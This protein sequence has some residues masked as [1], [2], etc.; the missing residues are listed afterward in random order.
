MSNQESVIV[1]EKK[2]F[3]HVG[4]GQRGIQNILGNFKS[5]EWEEIRLDV[6]SRVEPD[7]LCSMVD[8]RGKVETECMDAVW[9]SH[10]VEHLYPHEVIPTFQEFYRVLKPTG[11]LSMRLPDIQAVAEQIAQ[12][13]LEEALYQSPNGP[14]CPLDILY[15][16]RP[17]LEKGNYFMAHKTGFTEKTLA[18]KLYQAGFQTVSVE[19]RKYDLWAVALKVKTSAPVFARGE[20]QQKPAEAPVKISEDTVPAQIAS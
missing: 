20:A 3:L 4:C 19:R 12:G 13:N 16:F 1:P 6:D 17:A 11:F 2:R 8:M 15:G 7:I 5:E 10:T 9:T 14:V 18:E